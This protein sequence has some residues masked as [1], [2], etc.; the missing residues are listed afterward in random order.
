MRKRFREELLTTSREGQE[1]FFKSV[2]GV[3]GEEW[4]EWSTSSLEPSEKGRTKS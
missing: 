2:K 3:R 4:V 1:W